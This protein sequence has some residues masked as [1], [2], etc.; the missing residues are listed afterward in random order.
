M[1]ENYN[2]SGIL[3]KDCEVRNVNGNQVINFSIPVNKSYKDKKTDEWVNVT[4]W[5]NCIWWCNHENVA[6]RLVKDTFVSIVGE[7]IAS[8]YL[9]DG[10]PIAKLEC[11]VLNLQILGMKAAKENTCSTHESQSEGLSQEA[12]ADDLPF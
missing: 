5:V 1:T 6:K 12:D 3:A 11:K 10:Q 7:P 9:K 4:K 2:L 8:A